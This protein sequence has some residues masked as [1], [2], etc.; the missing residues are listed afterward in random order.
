MSQ[1]QKTEQVRGKIWVSRSYPKSARKPDEEEQLDLEVRKFET[2]P[3]WVKAGYGLTIN[4]GNYES[5]RCDCGVT[6][7]CYLEE[8]PDAMKKAWEI[9]EAEIQ[10]QRKAVSK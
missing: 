9:A 10:K 1:N 8:V 6:L 7:P 2:E 3:A 5:A 4:L